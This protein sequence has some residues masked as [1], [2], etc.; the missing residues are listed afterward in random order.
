MHFFQFPISSAVIFV[1]FVC[2]E[3]RWK[4]KTWLSTIIIY[5]VYWNLEF[6]S[7]FCRDKTEHLM[8]ISEEKKQEIMKKE[9]AK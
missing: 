5:Y 8:E 6:T 1:L 7:H 9:N 3:D 4:N 2:I